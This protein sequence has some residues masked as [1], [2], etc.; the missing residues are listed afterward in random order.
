MIRFRNLTAP[1]CIAALA[2]PVGALADDYRVELDLTFDRVDFPGD[3]PNFDNVG[4]SGT[5][6]FEPVVTDGLP[7]REA[8]FLKRSS[9]VSAGATRTDYGDQ[10]LDVFG[11]SAGYYLPNTIF[12]GEV[13][14]NYVDDFGGDQHYFSGALGVAPIDGLLVTTQ[15]DEDGWDPNAT[16]RYVG[17]LPNSN[18]YAASVTVVDP[19]LGDLTW[20]VGF[21]YYFDPT[22]SVGINLT[23]YTTGLRAE[24]FFTPRFSVTGYVDAGDDDLGDRFGARLAW[25][26]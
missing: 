26:F 20:G 24:K 7:L 16:A 19:D 18:F 23:E 22:L 14:Y 15:F 21:D 8:A 2:L 13:N 10:E 17:K 25:R 5:Y 3:A 6:F 11:A 1:A 9:F 4:V 12:Y